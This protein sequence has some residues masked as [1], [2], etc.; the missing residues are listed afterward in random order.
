MSA[1]PPFPTSFAE[2]I[3]QARYEHPQ[4]LNWTGTARRVTHFPMEA[5]R[6]RFKGSLMFDDAKERIF[7]AT[8]RRVWLP[9]GRYLYAAGRDLHQVNNCVLL[10]CPDDR[11]GWATHSYQSEMSLMTG[12]GIGGW[13]GD[14]RPAGSLIRRTGGF[15]SG[16]LSK[17]QMVNEQGRHIMQG[18]ARRSA[19]WAG[20][21]W[22]HADIFDFIECKDW[23]DEV[24]ALKEKDWTFPAPM[25]TTN[26]SVTLDDDFF[27]AWD[28]ND[29][30]SAP[31]WNDHVGEFARSPVAPD[32]GSWHDWAH[33]VYDT[34]VGH[35]LKHGEPGFT[36][37]TGDKA[38]EVLRNACTEITSADD[39]D[40]CNLGSLVLPAFSDPGQFES[41]VRDA[42]LYLTAG[43]V[44]SDVPYE[45]VAEVREKN[46]RLGLGIMGLH[47]F[48]MKHGV[49][50]GSD[51]SFELLEP[52]G[53][54]YARALEFAWD[55]Q[56]RAGLSRSVGA[57]AVAP[58]GT[59]GILAGTTPSGDPLFSAAERRQ[60]KIA[61]VHGKDRY[62][63]HVVVDPV[64]KRLV[65]EGVD[66]TLI[67]DA[68]TLAMYPE[69]RL[70]MQAFW[71]QYTDHAISS[72]V[73]LPH[74]MEG[75]EAHD[76][77][78]TMMEYLP[79]LRGIT[80]YPD[81]ARAGQ[82]RTPVDL[83]W[84]LANEGVREG[85]TENV[86]GVG[87]AACGV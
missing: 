37:D 64:A 39:S 30:A 56:D 68:A 55:W 21:P 66:P 15:A 63:E 65:A 8:K 9:G 29:N 78:R 28:G 77:G 26:I 62:E 80:V 10:R 19:I 49:R 13:Y 38:G 46:R 14:V 24:K 34:A 41:A 70:A 42:S 47:E 67:E 3:Y 12:A 71:Q 4:D 76:F 27:Y 40:I 85:V 57:T 59:I 79:R 20:L 86:C 69:R 43:S 5:L 35:M 6:S 45:K 51:D 36:I 75:A 1:A 50:Y 25:D 7:Q 33:R 82:P 16:P 87:E 48:C 44:Y 73:N 2:N 74:V 32:G 53:R 61:S 11:E 31:L 58:N 81:G 84:A 23:S 18:G 54:A 83:E 17:M 60:V 52:Y 22:W 72:T